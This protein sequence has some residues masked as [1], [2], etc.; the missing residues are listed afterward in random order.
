MPLHRLALIIG[1]GM[2]MGCPSCGASRVECSVSDGHC[3]HGVAVLCDIGSDEAGDYAVFQERDCGSPELCKT[4]TTNPS[5]PYPFCVLEAEPNLVCN[6]TY[7]PAPINKPQESWGC[8]SSTE[9]VH[10][11]GGFVTGRY[12]CLSCN[13]TPEC[14]GGN[15]SNCADGSPCAA[16]FE[17]DAAS[18]LCRYPCDCEDYTACP[19]CD[20][21]GLQVGGIACHRGRCH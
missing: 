15:A 17:C 5:R 12:V 14:Q 2:L 3:D 1:I 4:D 19:V 9:L 21:V 20:N 8:A 7:W 10:C 6:Q 18:G 13:A 11:L 16:G